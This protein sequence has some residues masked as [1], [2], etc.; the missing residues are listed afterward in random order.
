MTYLVYIACGLFMVICQTTLIPRLAFV[1]YCFDLLLPLVIYLAAF[2]P[3]HEALPFTVFIGVLVDYLSAG[4][5][6]LYLTSYFW[7]FISAR[8]AATVVRAENPIMIVLTL[9]GAVAAQNALFYAILG[10]FGQGDFR[11]GF[12]VQVMA[13]QIGWVLL[14]GPFIAWGMRAVHR[15]SSQRAKKTKVGPPATPA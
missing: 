7:L 5:F 2:R 4:P 10:T 3:L 13:E 11:G 15:F 9:I 12:A 14:I 1:G 6:G 8:A